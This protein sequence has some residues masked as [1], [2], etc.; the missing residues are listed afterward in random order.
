MKARKVMIHLEVLSDVPI[1]ML[2]EKER[3]AWRKDA[4]GPE[5][6]DVHQ[7]TAQVVKEEK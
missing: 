5:L 7:V 3:W 1:K 6:V 2:K 4:I